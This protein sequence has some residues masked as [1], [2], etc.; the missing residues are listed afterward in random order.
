MAEPNEVDFETP[1]STDDLSKGP[2]AAATMG[3]RLVATATVVSGQIDLAGLLYA[4][5][6][7]SAI[8]ATMPDLGGSLIVHFDPSDL[9][10]IDAC[11][12]D[13]RV[14]VP[15]VDRKLV[16]VTVIAVQL[17]LFDPPQFKRFG[18][19]EARRRLRPGRKPRP[20]DHPWHP[21]LGSA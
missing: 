8:L 5:E 3:Q 1:P 13:D 18:P 10:E 4:S 2:H 17:G 16:A 9:A 19:T 6:E 15:A 12:G 7:L 20:V 11:I 14:C 21:T